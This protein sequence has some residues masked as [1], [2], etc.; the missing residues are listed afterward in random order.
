MKAPGLAAADGTFE[1]VDG[2]I[3]FRWTKCEELSPPAEVKELFTAS[4]DR[5]EFAGYLGDK[6]EGLTPGDGW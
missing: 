5:S 2:A 6:P 3:V 4:A 1:N